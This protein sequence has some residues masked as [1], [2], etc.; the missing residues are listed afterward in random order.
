MYH[1]RLKV[2]TVF[3]QPRSQFTEDVRDDMVTA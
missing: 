3:I 1:E 2:L